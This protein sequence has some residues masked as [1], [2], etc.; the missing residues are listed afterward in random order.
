MTLS[1]S[2]NI[3]VSLAVSSLARLLIKGLLRT[4]SLENLSVRKRF[5]N[6]VFLLVASFSGDRGGE[7]GPVP[8]C[9]ED[10]GDV[11][12]TLLRRDMIWGNEA[13]ISGGKKLKILHLAISFFSIKLY[14]LNSR[15]F[16]GPGGLKYSANN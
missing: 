9:T 7:E 4:L 13:E 8:P 11:V 5:S 12:R 16:S 15:F 10:E 6:L 1:A 2:L 3:G 14:L